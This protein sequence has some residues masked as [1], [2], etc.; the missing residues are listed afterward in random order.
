ML[1]ANRLILDVLE[2]ALEGELI[3]STVEGRVALEAGR[4]WCAPPCAGRRSS[5]RAR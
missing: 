3:D 2:P 1:E 5:G 4:A